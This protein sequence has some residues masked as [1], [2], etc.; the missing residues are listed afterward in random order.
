M[1]ESE[2]IILLNKGDHPSFDSV[3]RSHYT[4]MYRYAFLFVKDEVLADVSVP[5][6]QTV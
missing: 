5:K 2:Q 1:S 6:N 3:Y 4:G